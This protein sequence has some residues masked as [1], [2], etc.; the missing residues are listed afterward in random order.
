MQRATRIAAQLS[1]AAAIMTAPVAIA[2]T[3]HAGPYNTS[4]ITS[5]TSSPAPGGQFQVTASGF[6]PNSTVQ[7]FVHSTPV[8]LATVT[9]DA[10]GVASAR[11]QIPSSFTAGSSHQILAEGVD[12]SGGP[13]TDTLNITLAGGSTLPFT[14]VDALGIGAAGAG[15]VGFGSFLVFAARRKRAA[16]I[17]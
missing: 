8:L 11:V 14:G 7:M 17:V 3:A 9:A 12:P 15:L 2:A 5:S 1:L 10:N 6:K 13:L 4:P 16:R